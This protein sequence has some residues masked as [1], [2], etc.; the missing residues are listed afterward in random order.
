MKTHKKL[1][2]K[3]NLSSADEHILIEIFTS[4]LIDEKIKQKLQLEDVNFNNILKRANLIKQVME[5]TRTPNHEDSHLIES[6]YQMMINQ[7]K[8]NNCGLNHDT[9]KCLASPKLLSKWRKAAGNSRDMK[10]NDFSSK[11]REVHF[12]DKYFQPKT[13]PHGEFNQQN[14]EYQRP[15]N[16]N[17]SYNPRPYQFKKK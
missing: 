8:C 17:S 6:I 12:Q 10:Y 5:N 4:A 11:R 1:H 7:K 16:V 13:M 2:E 3:E 9:S 14:N 15:N